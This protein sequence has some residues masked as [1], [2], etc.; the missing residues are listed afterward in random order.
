LRLCIRRHLYCH[1]YPRL[2]RFNERVNPKAFFSPALLLYVIAARGRSPDSVRVLCGY[3]NLGSRVLLE[4]SEED[5]DSEFPFTDDPMLLELV[6]KCMSV[7]RNTLQFY[8]D[9][10]MR[11]IRNQAQ[12]AMKHPPPAT[13]CLEVHFGHHP[14]SK[15]LQQRRRRN[16]SQRRDL[17]MEMM[18]MNSTYLSFFTRIRSQSQ[19]SGQRFLQA[20]FFQTLSLT[21]DGL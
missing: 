7:P 3:K 11:R 6:V 4:Q 1:G 8:P 19:L 17:M 18:T 21:L 9:P 20:T 12:K 2:V 10:T 16:E 13:V 15:A 5:L 14:Y